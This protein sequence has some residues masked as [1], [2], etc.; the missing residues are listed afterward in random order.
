M[1]WGRG[2]FVPLWSEAEVD[3]FDA[4][5]AHA[6][7]ADIFNPILPMDDFLFH[8]LTGRTFGGKEGFD[9]H[10]FPFLA[11]GVE[12]T[13]L[14]KD[15]FNLH[16]KVKVALVLDHARMDA[17]SPLTGGGV[18][19]PFGPF[20]FPLIVDGIFVV[21]TD[22]PVDLGPLGAGKGN[23]IAGLFQTGIGHGVETDGSRTLEVLDVLHQFIGRHLDNLSCRFSHC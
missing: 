13:R 16:R 22:H 21:V 17:S 6:E 7:V 19:V 1:E 8:P 23:R 5:A 14:F 9:F 15:T 20:T 2:T 4:L 3:D 10:D 11:V 12:V 18:K